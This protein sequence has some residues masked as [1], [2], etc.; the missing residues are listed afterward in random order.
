MTASA[1]EELCTRIQKV[2]TVDVKVMTTKMD[3]IEENAEPNAET[4]KEGGIGEE[5]II[6]ASTLLGS[7]A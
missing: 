5:K 3:S 2:V 6:F 1:I 7:L 4:I